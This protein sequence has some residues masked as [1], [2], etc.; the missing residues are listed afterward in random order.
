MFFNASRL[1]EGGIRHTPKKVRQ[2]RFSEGEALR[3]NSVKANITEWKA[4][5]R[6]L[7][8]NSKWEKLR[9]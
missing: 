8:T 1:N 4:E 2:Q 5:K 9:Q 3:T 6:Q 7:R